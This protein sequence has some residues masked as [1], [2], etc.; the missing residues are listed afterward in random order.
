MKHWLTVFI[1]LLALTDCSSPPP[2]P[3]S[4]DPACKRILFIGNSY[5]FVNDLPATLAKLAES[6]G[7]RIETGMAATGGWTLAQH[8]Q[9]TETLDKIKSSKWDFVV[10]QEQS[11]IPASEQARNTGMYPAARTLVAKIHAA[12][13]TP[14]FFVTWAH[15]K[16]WPDNGLNGYEA[17]QL[18]IDEGYVRIAQELNAPLAPVGF[19]WYKYWRQNPQMNLWQNDGTHPNES[20]TYLAACVFYAALYRQSPEGLSYRG[21]L[22][23]DEA[24]ILQKI[25]ADTVLKE[26]G[27]WNLP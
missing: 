16:G 15:H 27:R 7:K 20:G 18:Q 22:S 6:G 17:M 4:D 11:Q 19:A 23:A 3:C 9:S 5:T 10:L 24:K 13:A 14:M 25:A 21:N 2:S 1:L 26:P 12:G 8:A